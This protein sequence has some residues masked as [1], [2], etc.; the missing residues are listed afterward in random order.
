[1]TVSGGGGA[2]FN[3]KLWALFDYDKRES[4]V[5]Q[6]VAQSVT[7]NVSATIARSVSY[8]AQHPILQW[9]AGEL[10]TI[11]FRAKL[12]AVDST[13]L[14][15]GERL[16]RLEALVKRDVKI[17]RPPVCAFSI[18]DVDSLAIDCLVR[19]LGGIT[20]DELRD[21]GSLR[22]VTL[23]ISLE[24]FE[25]FNVEATDPSVPESQTRI[26][27]ARAGDSY[28]SIAL[29]EYADPELGVLL[30]QLNPRVPG[31]DLSTLS[32]KDPI[33]VFSES[34]LRTLEI[35]PE[36]HAFKTGENFAAAERA[37]RE[38][39]EARADDA[40][41]TIYAENAEDEF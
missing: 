7:K 32:A 37:R 11:S 34:F 36:F 15:V 28:E 30:R 23:Q 10:E 40:F 26:R 41:L 9:V 18:G 1:M 39:F 31:M 16:E 27:R 2:G 25:E 8:G 19:S 6:F 17:G 33:H 5:G 13:D 14:R 3:P 12:W 24:R 4:I 20:Y 35:A 22:G 29:D 21:D 38:I